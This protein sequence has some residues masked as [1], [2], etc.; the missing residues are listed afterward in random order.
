MTPEQVEKN[1]A[2]ARAYYHRNKEL[3][4]QKNKE[5]ALAHKEDRAVYRKEYYEANK[6]DARV[7][8]QLHK[9]EICARQKAKRVLAKEAKR[10][11][12]G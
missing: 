7:Y 12:I 1:R 3:L 6:H 2:S 5:Y 10:T 8:Y 11:T 9:E 4:K